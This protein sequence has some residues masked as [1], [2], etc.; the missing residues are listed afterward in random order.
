MKHEV[1]DETLGTGTSAGWPSHIAAHAL[2]PYC[3]DLKPMV[4]CG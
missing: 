3:V 4:I 2:A 1:S